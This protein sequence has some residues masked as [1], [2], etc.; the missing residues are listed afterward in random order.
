MLSATLAPGG[1]RERRTPEGNR[2]YDDWSGRDADYYDGSSGIAVRTRDVT[3]GAA[4]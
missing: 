3:V 4:V 2:R 1:A